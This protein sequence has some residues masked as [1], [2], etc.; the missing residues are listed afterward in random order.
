MADER[1]TKGFGG[2]LEGKKQ[3]GRSRHRWEIITKIDSQEIGWGAWTSL[4]WLR[5]G[6]SGGILC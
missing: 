1:C 3:H 6:T 2:E 4:V 5:T